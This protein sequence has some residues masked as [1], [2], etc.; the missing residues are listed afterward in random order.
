[1]DLEAEAAKAKRLM[2]A[3]L[4]NMDNWRERTLEIADDCNP[5]HKVKA[6]SLARDLEMARVSLLRLSGLKSDD[7]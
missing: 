7:T 2:I 3:V 4:Q 6:L 5:Q 1:M